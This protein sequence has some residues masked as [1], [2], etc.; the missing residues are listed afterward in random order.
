MCVI[1]IDFSSVS[2][3]YLLDFRNCGMFSPFYYRIHVIFCYGI[4]AIF[5]YRIH[6]IFCYGIHAIFY[7]RIHVIFCYRI[8]QED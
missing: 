2:M 6:V 1:G 4:H 8:G 7:Y 5:Y 3:I